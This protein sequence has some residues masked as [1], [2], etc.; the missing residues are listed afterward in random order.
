MV[1]STPKLQ[2]LLVKVTDH[3]L[4]PLCSDS[5]LQER[6]Q[7]RSFSGPQKGNQTE[8]FCSHPELP[9][10][11]HHTAWDQTSHRCVRRRQAVLWECYT[12]AI[13]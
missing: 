9:E 1:L 4:L 12:P 6:S 11:G 2:V 8:P 7:I 3:F 10:Q 5:G 13:L